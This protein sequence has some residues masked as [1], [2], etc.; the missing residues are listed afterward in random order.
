MKKEILDPLVDSGIIEKNF[1]NSI[2]MNIY[3]DGKEGLAQH[4]D[5]AVRFKQ[6]IYTVKLGSDARLSFGSQFY[7]YLNGAFCIPCPRGVV[8]VMEEFSYAANSAKHC[9]RP[10]DMSGRSITLILRQIHPFIM[11]EARKYD[12][13]IDLPT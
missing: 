7:G 10:C 11:E 3:H 2:A 13:E 1:I 6:P 9:V 12:A 8:C 4:F 5:D